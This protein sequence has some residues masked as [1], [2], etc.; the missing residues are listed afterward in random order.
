MNKIE[1]EK[2][3]MARIIAFEL[4]PYGKLHAKLYEGRAMCASNDN[5]AECTKINKVVDKL[6]NAGYRKIDKES[7]VIN[8][9]DNQLKPCPF[10]GGKAKLAKQTVSMW[11][12]QFDSYYVVCNTCGA[13]SRISVEVAEEKDKAIEAWNMRVEK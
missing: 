7:V 2:E 11:F 9:E 6:Y 8:K 10:C 1:R 3:E 13:R 12:L 4:C 5:F